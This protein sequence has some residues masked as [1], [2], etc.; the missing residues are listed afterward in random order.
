M[1][2]DDLFK[3]AWEEDTANKLLKDGVV[4]QSAE[5]EGINGT[6]LFS[7]IIFLSYMSTLSWQIVIDK[8]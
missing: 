4:Q 5:G 7:H 8:R 6:L 1:Q 2:F 3:I